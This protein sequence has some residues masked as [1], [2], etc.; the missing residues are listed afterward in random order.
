MDEGETA[1]PS[2]YHAGNGLSDAPP[3]SNQTFNFSSGQSAFP[4]GPALPPT[5]GV[6]VS[7]DGVALPAAGAT[8]VPAQFLP[9]NSDANPNSTGKR[10]M[11]SSYSPSP[12]PLPPHVV[13]PL[14][15]AVQIPYHP[16]PPLKRWPNDYTVSEIAEGFRQMDTLIAQRPSVTQRIAFER[17]FGCRYVKSTV[18]RHRGVWRRADAGVRESFEKLGSDERA[19][20]GEFVRR[21][22]GRQ[23]GKVLDGGM[24]EH[25]SHPRHLEDVDE[26]DESAMSSPNAPRMQSQGVHLLSL[27]FCGLTIL[28][29]FQHP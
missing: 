8:A 2:K 18:C 21:V 7:I 17:V 3:Q 13:A 25:P 14:N 9:E 27:V 15:P 1:P 5:S 16:H 29:Q 28:Y 10:Y 6:A 4:M 22:E 11:F 24:M 19:V 23:S 12:V 20:W 26:G